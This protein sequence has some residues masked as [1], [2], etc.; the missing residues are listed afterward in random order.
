MSEKKSKGWRE[1]EK[2]KQGREREEKGK[3]GVV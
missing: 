1:D 2:E 3:V